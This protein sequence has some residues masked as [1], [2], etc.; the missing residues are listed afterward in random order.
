MLHLSSAAPN[1]S[2]AKSLT[3]PAGFGHESLVPSAWALMI[4]TLLNVAGGAQHGAGAAG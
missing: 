4:M 1:Q 2:R 3:S